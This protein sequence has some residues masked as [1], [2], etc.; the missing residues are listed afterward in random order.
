MRPTPPQRLLLDR[1][2]TPIGVALLVSDE[3]GTLRALDWSDHQHRMQHLLR[4][5]YGSAS[6]EHGAAP[7]ATKHHLEKYFAGDLDC[8]ALIAWTTAGTSFQRAV[9]AALAAIPAGTAMSYGALA[10]QLGRPASVRAVGGANGSNPI[11][12]VVPCH[13]LVGADGALTG[14]GGGVARKLWLLRHEG[15]TFR[16]RPFDASLP[17][18]RAGSAEADPL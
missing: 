2:A 13:R 7:T 17:G 16:G 18:V 15:A 8:L 14:Y 4:L 12:V 11:S 3:T 6:L 9:W 1:L 10:A 5:Q